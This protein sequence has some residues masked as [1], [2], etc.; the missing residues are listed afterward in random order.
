MSKRRHTLPPEFLF[1]RRQMVELARAGRPSEGT[2]QEFRPTSQSI[3]NWVAPADRDEGR[4]A[5]C[6]TTAN[7]RSL[8]RLGGGSSSAQDGERYPPQAALFRSGDETKSQGSMKFVSE[9]RAIYSSFVMLP[10]LGC[11]PPAAITR[12]SI[13]QPP[14]VQR[15]RPS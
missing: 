4:R 13:D 7:E 11:P 2:C 14:S 1:C 10:P 15:G 9:N 5:D 3:R 6:L 8:V 12:G